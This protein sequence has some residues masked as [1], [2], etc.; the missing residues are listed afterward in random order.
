MRVYVCLGGG[1]Y[2]PEII[3]IAEDTSRSRLHLFTDDSC[4][5]FYASRSNSKKSF[6]TTPPSIVTNSRGRKNGE[7]MMDCPSMHKCVL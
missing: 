2:L 3:Y 1:S 6:R 5:A 4:V 7:I